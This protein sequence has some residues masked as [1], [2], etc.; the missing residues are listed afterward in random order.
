MYDEPMILYG[1]SIHLVHSQPIFMPDLKSIEEQLF[2]ISKPEEF[3]ALSLE[4]FHFQYANNDI[5]RQFVDFLKVNP[6]NVQEYT[7]IPFLPI[8]FFKAHQVTTTRFKPEAV[9]TSSGTTGQQTSTHEVKSLALY[10]KSF[11]KTFQH[12]FGK[13]REMVILALLPSYLEREGSSLVYM[14]DKLIQDSA[15]EESGFYLDN[16]QELAD[17]LQALQKKQIPTVLIGVTYALLDLAEQFPIAFPE[18]ILMETGGMKGRRK[19]M[20]RSDLHAQLSQAFQVKHICSEYGMTELL[21]QAYAP[22]KGVFLTPPWMKV[23]VRDTNDPL[24]YLEQGRTGGLNIIDLANLYS[25][26]FIATKDLGKAYAH[27]GFEVLGRFDN[28][29]IRGCNLL[30]D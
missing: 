14:A 6:F 23:M 19:E 15:Y 1:K 27:G 4:I 5:Y 3:N 10:E 8:E 28:S 22:K 29:D 18:L 24:S 21:S 16:L 11:K 26:S 12:F 20:V 9:F 2:R 30:V 7:Q 13:T 17:Q 25:C